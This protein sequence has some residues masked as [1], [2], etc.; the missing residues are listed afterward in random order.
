MGSL[1]RRVLWPRQYDRSG[2]FNERLLAGLDGVVLDIGCGAFRDKFA[3]PPTS[4]Y[5]GLD[6]SGRASHLRGDGHRLPVADGCADWV[7]L[8]AVLEHVEQ[9]EAVLAEA[10]RALRPGG[11]AYIAV[12]FLQ[13]EHAAADYWRWT[14]QG[15]PRLLAAAGFDI[16]EMGT[17]GGILV[18]LDYLLWHALRHMKRTRAWLL[19]PMLLVLKTLVQPLAR[20]DG[21][22]DDPLF[23]T[24]FHAL[25]TV[26]GA[27]KRQS[28]NGQRRQ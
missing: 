16:V 19:L 17:N 13:M 11:H 20:L 18:L 7:L 6:L 8:V 21:S 28:A 10:R 5:Y 24:S 23:A 25:V 1:A 9:P 14:G 3:L 22:I 26:P 4:H 15:F 27:A 12:P 2:F